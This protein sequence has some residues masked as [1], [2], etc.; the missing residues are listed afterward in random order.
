MTEGKQV[1]ISVVIRSLCMFRLF[2]ANNCVSN[3]RLLMPHIAVTHTMCSDQAK[4]NA[5]AKIFTTR[6]RSLRRLCFHRFLPVHRG[7]SAPLHAGI[8]TLPGQTPPRET[9]PWAVHAEIWSTSG[10]Y[11]SHWN[12]FLS[13]MFSVYSLIFFTCA[14]IFLC[15]R[16]HFRLV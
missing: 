10:R 3:D 7:V 9:P 12:A 4:V 6:K 8:H 16:F 13:L 5:Q 14:L 1:S 11:A 2:L 15:F